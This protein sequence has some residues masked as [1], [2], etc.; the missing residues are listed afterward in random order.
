[1]SLNLATE[2]AGDAPLGEPL[3]P[4]DEVAAFLGVKRSTVMDLAQ[5]RGGA[6]P[7]PAVHINS[8]VIRFRPEDVRAFVEATREVARPRLVDQLP[9]RKAPSPGRRRTA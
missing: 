1:M 4:P 5:G 3:M 7:L 8:R 9:R 2:S 6:A